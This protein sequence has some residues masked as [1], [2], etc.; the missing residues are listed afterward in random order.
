MKKRVLSLFLALTLC[1]T[2]LP[3]SAFAEGVDGSAVSSEAATV[4]GGQPAAADAASVTAEDGTETTYSSFTDAWAAATASDGSTLK[5]LADGTL[6][7]TNTDISKSLALDLNGYVLGSNGSLT[8]KSGAA[9]TVKNAGGEK[10]EKPIQTGL[11]LKLLAE[12]GGSFTCTDGGVLSL[13]LLSAGT[14]DYNIKLADGE[15]H[16]TFVSFSPSDESATVDDMLKAASG[17]ALHAGDSGFDVQIARSTLIDQINVGYK[18][19]YVGA[20]SGHSMDANG[21]CIYCGASYVASVKTSDGETTNYT[22][23]DD[24][25]DAVKDGD[26][27]TLQG[28]AESTKWHSISTALTL[29]LNGKTVT[30]QKGKHLS[31]RARVIVQDS[32]EAQTGKMYCATAGG[33]S[34]Q[35]LDVQY[36]GDLIIKSGT[37]DGEIWARSGSESTLT[38]EGGTFNEEVALEAS[39]SISLSG[40]EFNTIWYIGNGSFLDLLAEGYAFYDNDGKLVNASK[41]TGRYLDNVKVQEHKQHTFTDGACG[42]GYACPHTSVNANGICAVCEKRFAASVTDDGTVTYYDTFDSALVYARTQDGCT[43][44]LLADVTEATV[45]INNPFIFDLNGHN[46]DQGLSTEAKVTIKDSGTKKGKIGKVMVSD[47]KVPGLTLGSL[48]E[49]GYAFKYE[50]GYWADNSHAQTL[51]GYQV[52]VEK[53][54]IQSVNVLAK[55]KNNQKI[56]TMAYGTTGEVTL[57]SSCQMSETGT[58][59]SCVWYKLTDDTAIPPL[60]G[61]TGTSYTLPAD[62]PAGTHTYWVT[63]TSEGYSKS[64]EITITV[65]PISLADAE[66]TVQNP[67]YNGKEQEP[68]VT[69]TLGDKTLSRDNDYNVQVTKETDAGSYKLTIKGGGNYSGEI[70]NV[71]WKIEPMKID[72]VMV[73]SGI[74][75]VYDGTAEINMTA[76]EWAKVLTFKTL[77]PAPT[78]VSVPSSAYTISEAYFVEKSGEETIH[79]PDA[80]EKYGITFKITLNSKNYVL[81]NYYDKGPTASKEYTQSGGATFTITKADAPNLTTT[82]EL[83]VTNG[84]AKTYEVDLAALLPGLAGPREYGNITYEPDVQITATGYYTTGTAKVENGK[85]LLPILKNDVDTPS[86]IGKVIATVTTTNYKDITLTIPV[87]ARNKLTPNQTGVTVSASAITYGQALADSKLTTT[88]QMK[89]PLTGNEVK[90]TFAW[91]DG[92]VKPDHAGNYDA[93]WTFTPAE[94]CEEYATATGTVTINVKPAELTGVSV[95]ASSTYYTGK[96]Q[97]ASRIASGQSVDGTPV[98][99]TYSD[100]VDGNYTSDGPTFTDA[101]TYTVYYKAEAANHITATGTFSVTIKPLPISLISVSSISKTY[102]GSANV[103]VDASKLT[104]IS[105]A[106]KAQ[107]IKLPDTAL[108]FSSAQFTKEQADGSYKPS[109]EVGNGKALSFTM[110]LA[111]DNYVFEGETEGTKTNHY[112]FVTGDATKFTITEAAAPTNIQTGKLNVINGTKLEYT[113]DAK[114]L[115]P[116]APKGTYGK[117]SYNCAFPFNLENGYSVDDT[118]F[119]IVDGVLTLTIDAQS[120]VKTGKIGTIPV[121]VTTDNYKPFNLPLDL[122]A[123]NK[124]T[125]VAAGDITASEITYGDALSKSTISGKMKDPDTG[126]TVEG[127]F[128]WK[129]PDLVPDIAGTYVGEWKFTPKDKSTYTEATGKVNVTVNNAKQSATLVMQGYTYGETPFTPDLK[130]RTGNLEMPVT[131]RYCAEGGGTMQEWDIDN[132]PALSAGTYT[133][134][135]TI[136]GT[137]NYDTFT[138]ADVQFTVAKA[139]PDFTSGTTY[140][141]PTGLTATYGQ[142]LADVTLTNPAGNLDGTWRWMDS[143]ESVGDASTAAKKFKAKFTPTDTANY[144]TVENIEL[145]VTVNQADG[146]SLKTVDLTQ[147]YTDTSE[148][149]YTPD[150]SGLPEGQTWS[151][152][153]SASIKLPTQD[154]TVDGRELTYAISGGKAGDKI[155]ITL[156]ASCNNYADFTITLTITLTG[157]DD[158]QELKLTGGTTVVYGQTLTLSTSGG[159][160]S[161]AVTYTVTNGTG[162][163]TIDP[164]GALTPVRVGSVTVT[165]TKAG[166]SEYNAVT[167][168]PV[169]ITITKATPTGAPKYTKIATSGKTLADA[170]LTLDGSTLKPNT[171]TLEWVDNKG[172]AL[173]GDTKVEAN[174]SYKWRFTPTDTNY[175]TL[176]GEIELYHVSSGG[177]GGSSYSYHTIKA[178]AGAGGSISPS[179]NVSVREGRDQTFTITPDKG[180]AVSNVKIDGKSIGAVKSYTFENVSRTHTIEV[181][182]MKA[183]GTPQTGVFVDVATGSYYEDAVDWA[184]ENGITQGTDDTHFSPDGICTRAQIVTFLWRAAGSPAVNYLMPFTDVDESAY[185]AEAVRWAAST[186]IVTGLTETAFDPN[187]ACTR[188]QAAAM[189]YRHAQAQGKGFTGAWMFLLPFTDVSEWAYESVAWCYMNGV[190]TGVSETAFAPDDTCTRAQ[191]VTL[192]WRCTK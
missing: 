33:G 149:T 164:N 135:A 60:E 5:L 92:T 55:D 50:T 76:E 127:A 53:A 27:V 14:R 46:V 94:G 184:V 117:V 80:C 189:I 131:Y 63:F 15:S 121:Y 54:P 6:S 105:K 158:Q 116:D 173:P 157:K 68:K 180:Y 176:T 99:F 57:V 137:Q 109:P 74:S 161:G 155:T 78:P 188:A 114:Q 96:P 58:N 79:S 48:L 160:G 171:G 77:S 61:A 174:T 97:Y 70:E 136:A 165:A 16:C 143:T 182:F 91:K 84:L 12:K 69:V 4:E 62:L 71:D 18:I 100:K 154:F 132:P 19:F 89:C 185:Y 39:A 129:Y 123:V 26:T 162:E 83:Y 192:L 1:L 159:S 170:A 168:S 111:N 124:I 172:N 102:D 59:L 85:L 101:G 38:I 156:K 125:P 119:T 23:L 64:A 22:S 175:T 93:E 153:S 147:K 7:G 20:C 51:A 28:D 108:T 44:K 112:D 178:T 36:R 67:T 43:L 107:N 191:I 144:N 95:K 169:E 177:G 24:A 52:T 128:S 187:G 73:S 35:V 148:H 34:S 45:M 56:S 167:S 113:Y 49:E 42:C 139:T 179:G 166:D 106:A 65:T 145:E 138:T 134:R 122:Y 146:G 29:D 40:G 130:D 140:K 190:T 152:G 37:F 21:T 90:G 120:G 110:T 30:I 25:L 126:A 8:I 9:L 47:E 141:K 186:G 32:S 104:F 98:T 81:Q 86:S 118:K 150:W 10:S 41:S 133:M 66:V 2:L 87:Y 151:Y 17:M 181:I 142:T 82:L 103:T 31:I 163:A 13:G 115:L 11:Y 72:S 183:N 3:T 75:K 88:G